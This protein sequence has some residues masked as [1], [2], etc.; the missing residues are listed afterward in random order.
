MAS[1]IAVMSISGLIFWLAPDWIIGLYIDSND[2]VNHQVV[3][4]ATS[5]LAIAALFQV[6]D[7]LQVAASGSL[8]GLKDTK[9]T[10]VLTLISYWGV[11]SVAGAYLCFWTQLRGSG[12]WLGMT[13]GLVTAAILL[14]WRFQ[15]RVKMAK[16]TLA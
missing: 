3:E 12:L 16:Q 2:S 10:M 14:T 6:V 11:G 7:G 1:C 13:L 15:Y 8:R 9:A 4:F 5:F